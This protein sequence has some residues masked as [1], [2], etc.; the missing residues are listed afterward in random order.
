MSA[1][2]RTVPSETPSSRAAC[3]V[4]SPRRLT[5][6]SVAMG[7]LTVFPHTSDRR[8]GVLHS[9]SRKTREPSRVSGRERELARADPRLAGST[10]GPARRT[11][12]VS[13]AEPRGG[14]QAPRGGP[15]TPARAAPAPGWTG[16]RRPPGPTRPGP[17]RGVGRV[18][19]GR[20]HQAARRPDGPTT[21]SG[22][23]VRRAHVRRE[24]PP[25]PA[26]L[27]PRAARLGW[28]GRPRSVVVR[29]RPRRARRGLCQQGAVEP[30][31]RRDL[32]LRA[33]ARGGGHDHHQVLAAHLQRRAAEALQ[34][35]RQGS[36]EALEAHRGGLP[37]PQEA[38]A[39]R[40]KPSRT[41]SS[42]RTP[43]GRRGIS[44]R[45]TPSATRASRS[46]RRLSPR[47]SA[48]CASAASRCRDGARSSAPNIRAMSARRAAALAL[49]TLAVALAAVGCG[50]EDRPLPAACA[51]GPGPAVRALGTAPGPVRL[52]GETKL[53][54]CVERAR[55]DA[56]IQTVGTVLDAHRRCARRRDGPQRRGRAAA[57][58]P[59]R[60]GPQ[61]RPA[62]E[63]DSPGARAPRRAGHRASTAP[64][65]P[66]RAA[67]DRGLAAGERTG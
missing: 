19:Q 8:R 44:S 10:R 32:R 29:P 56:D 26:P 37:E 54:S 55:S 50:D 28:D 46:S 3:E 39:V 15:G 23:A 33:D 45:E 27:Q 51:S 34:A 43:S 38:Q 30:R 53:S 4:E 6:D 57:R 18:R 62:H 60:R 22:R 12:P 14:G 52:A 65:A 63:R 59:H 67:F 25:L 35:P 61:G 11:R 64:P 58:L 42:A 9:L 47:S 48:G 13:E 21:C 36:A 7:Q 17:V 31:L 24:A 5:L 66:R 49:L 16:G 20:R 40:A 2:R 41:C 1:H